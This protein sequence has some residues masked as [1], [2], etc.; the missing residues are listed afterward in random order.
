MGLV[1]C[2]VVATGFYLDLCM[3]SGQLLDGGEDWGRLSSW[4]AMDDMK[5][6]LGMNHVVQLLRS[7]RVSFAVDRP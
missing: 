3:N 5:I 2:E 1:L 7:H 4:R 6:Y